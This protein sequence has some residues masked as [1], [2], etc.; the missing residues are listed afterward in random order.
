MTKNSKLIIREAIALGLNVEIIDEKKHLFN[1]FGRGKS[2]LVYELFSIALDPYTEV[3]RLSK[4]KDI[5]YTLWERNR[6]PFPPY[7][8]FRNHAEFS[9][10]RRDLKLDFPVITK[11]LR[12]LKSINVFTNIESRKEL[13]KI[14]KNYPKGFIV[15][16]MAFGN[17]YRLLVYKGKLLGALR[18][19]PPHIVGNGSD[20]VAFLIKQK[21]N[22]S[23]KKIILNET[24][25]KTLQKQGFDTQS[26]PDKDQMILLQHHSRLAEGGTTE[27]CT[28]KVHKEIAGLAWRAATAVNLN[29][30]GIDLICSDISLPPDKQN[31]YFLEV[32]TYPDLN[33]HY[34]PNSG[35]I[36]PV[37]KNILC[38]IFDI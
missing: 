3:Y 6:I 37:A 16:K 7:F 20:T 30:G 8:R 25:L 23:E 15:Q 36:R 10:K 35:P 11:E 12:G 34:H 1:I 29:L 26:I 4:D 32:N 5:T 33:I 38:D 14:A 18:M 2:M 21:N 22:L 19:V 9:D 24:A 13:D 27:D 17:E 31:V 28:D